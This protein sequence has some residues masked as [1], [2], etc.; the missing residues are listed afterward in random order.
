MVDVRFCNNDFFYADARRLHNVKAILLVFF[1]LLITFNDSAGQTTDNVYLVLQRLHSKSIVDLTFSRD[2]KW[3]ITGGEDNILK[4]WELPSGRIFADYTTTLQSIQKV[5]FSPDQR[6]I[7]VAGDGVINLWNLKSGKRHELSDGKSN[8]TSVLR[9]SPG[10]NLLASCGN[11]FI[12]CI[13]RVDEDGPRDKPIF[14]T[15]PNFNNPN[16]KSVV[17]KDE[18]YIGKY[19]IKNFLHEPNPERRTKNRV[20]SSVDSTG[21]VTTHIRTS[22]GRLSFVGKHKPKISLDMIGEMVFSPN[23]RWVAV[24]SSHGVDIFDLPEMSFMINLPVSDK[25]DDRNNVS[26][27]A[28][29][30][31]SNLLVVATVNKDLFLW[32]TTMFSPEY[33]AIIVTMPAIKS[34][35]PSNNLH[36]LSRYRTNEVLEKL[37]FGVDHDNLI[38]SPRLGSVYKFS[39][40]SGEAKM[41]AEWDTMEGKQV[42]YNSATNSFVFFKTFNRYPTLIQTKNSYVRTVFDQSTFNKSKFPIHKK[43]SILPDKNVLVTE[44]EHDLFLIN[45]SSGNISKIEMDVDWTVSGI[46]TKTIISPDGQWVV[47]GNSGGQ[48][49]VAPIYQTDKRRFVVGHPKNWITEII[50]SPDGKFLATGG[51]DSTIKL[52]TFPEMDLKQVFTLA[53]WGTTFTFSPDSSRFAYADI[54]GATIWDMK[55][56]SKLEIPVKDSISSLEFSYSESQQLLIGLDSGFI[57]EINLEDRIEHKYKV[58]TDSANPNV[59]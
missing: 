6:M 55:S 14:L 56:Q 35:D 16:K 58:R 42:A 12:A 36:L 50:F 49:C 28:V 18:L 53:W 52:W 37:W 23:G 38:V 20:S 32:D 2:G 51:R 45:L 4:L 17:S 57:Q 21:V 33:R 31:D 1:L 59:A 25:N 44:C 15:N 29:S 9:F 47:C 43:L 26:A 11:D 46:R 8:S 24:G 41:Q 5:A 39:L 27:M 3:I 19:N 30:D 54:K 22:S 40:K 13:W 7:A 48:I 10:S 34:L